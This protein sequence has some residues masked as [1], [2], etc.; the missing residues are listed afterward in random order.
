MKGRNMGVIEKSS[1]SF[2]L[3]SAQLPSYGTI[4]KFSLELRILL[5]FCKTKSFAY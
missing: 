5:N 1:H 2:G 3:P 4:A